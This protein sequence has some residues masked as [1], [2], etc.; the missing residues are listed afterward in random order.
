MSIDGSS[1]HGDIIYEIILEINHEMYIDLSAIKEDLP[2]IEL[3]FP[4][5]RTYGIM[6]RSGI[7]YLRYRDIIHR[8]WK[9]IPIRPMLNTSCSVIRYRLGNHLITTITN[10]DHMCNPI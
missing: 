8:P 10:F 2:G 1:H 4:P 3:T 5:T 6:T 7:S 9:R